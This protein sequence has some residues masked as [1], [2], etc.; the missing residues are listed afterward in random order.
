MYVVRAV[1][2]Q[3]HAGFLTNF[4]LLL[5]VLLCSSMYLSL[6]LCLSFLVSLCL[7]AFC[8][9]F[10]RVPNAQRLPVKCTPTLYEGIARNRKQDAGI[11]IESTKMGRQRDKIDKES[12]KEGHTMHIFICWLLVPGSAFVC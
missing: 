11:H 9:L 8:F 7:T 10:S 4:C 12:H 5:Y 3:F 2:F 1:P 6:S